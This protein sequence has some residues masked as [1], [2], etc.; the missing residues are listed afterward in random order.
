MPYSRSPDPL[1]RRPESSRHSHSLSLPIADEFCGGQWSPLL[2]PQIATDLDSQQS[3]LYPDDS[4]TRPLLRPYSSTE[5][6]DT[7]TRTLLHHRSY[8]SYEPVHDSA[9]H[10]HHADQDFLTED[11]AHGL[12]NDLEVS[13]R[14]SSLK[15]RA[16]TDTINQPVETAL[17]KSRQS[18]LSQCR[19]TVDDGGWWWHQMLVDRSLRSMAALTTVFALMMAILCIVYFGDLV[20]RVNPNSTS[21]GGISGESCSTMESGNIVCFPYITYGSFQY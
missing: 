16:V 13:Y 21:V 2:T 6:D 19:L 15:Q 4:S 5:A 9:D 20:H 7:S 14:L 10:D 12:Q 11:S 3:P 8:S 1:P 18:A 17:W